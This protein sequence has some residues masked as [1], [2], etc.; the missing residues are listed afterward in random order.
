VSARIVHIASNTFREAVR[1]RVL[2]NLIAFAL[3]LSGAAI[4][5]GQIS[6]DIEKLVVINLGLTAV[7]LFGVVIAIFIGIG[8]VSKEIEKRTL[9]TVLSRP[10]RRW[11]FIV[12][13]FFGL[14]GT[15]VVN[16]FFM[17]VGVFGALLYVAHHYHKPDAWVL[18]ALYFIVLQ[19][20]I[21]CALALLFSSFSSPLLSAVF[22]FS[23]FVIGNFAEDL[24][25]FAAMAHGVSRWLAT[26]A[27]YLVPNF[28]AMNVISSV[29]HEQPVAGHLIFYNTAY[30]LAYA[31]MAL[32]GAVLIFENRDLK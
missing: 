29:A 7:S 2:Y 4:L 9:Y 23:L 3:L 32:S 28:S 26:G 10:V 1:D 5:V 12:G 30:A 15:L 16:T 27:A 18:V 21:I 17:A 6:I 31:A 19:F 25:G 14:A 13:K 8:L 11:E 22:A 24:R 20:L